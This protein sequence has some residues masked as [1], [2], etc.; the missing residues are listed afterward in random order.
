MSDLPTLRARVAAER[1]SMEV[2]FY[3]S[4]VVLLQL[5]ADLLALVEGQAAELTVLRGALSAWGRWAH[6]PDGMDGELFDAALEATPADRF[7]P[8]EDCD[9]MAGGHGAP[10]HCGHVMSQRAEAGCLIRTLCPLP[11]GHEGPHAEALGAGD[12]GGDGGGR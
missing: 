6:S 3:P 5:A 2:A 8:N 12:G 10:A 11:A 9:L 4:K 7:P 1:A